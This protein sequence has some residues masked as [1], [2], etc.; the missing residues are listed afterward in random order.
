[1]RMKRKNN[2]LSVGYVAMKELDEI[3]VKVRGRHFNCGREIQND[4]IFRRGSPL[5]S[6]LLAYV[7]CEVDF[8]AGER[9][10]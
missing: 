4:W 2:R 8:S 1:M 6:H 9:L 10:R 5:G 7:N 3:A